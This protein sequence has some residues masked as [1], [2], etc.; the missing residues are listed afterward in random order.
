M[1]R[2]LT[3]LVTTT[4]FAL[5]GGVLAAGTAGAAPDSPGAPAPIA[6]GSADDQSVFFYCHNRADSSHPGRHTG[7]DDAP[8]AE[9]RNL[10]GRC[11]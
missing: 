6:V 8:V 7:W 4:A 9:R 11:L 10:G 2:T 5:G 3:V 1:R